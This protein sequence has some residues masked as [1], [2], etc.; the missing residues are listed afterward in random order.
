[1]DGIADLDY[2]YDYT[3]SCLLGPVYLL[4]DYCILGSMG[5]IEHA[6]SL[7]PDSGSF[8]GPSRNLFSGCVLI[9]LT[10]VSPSFRLLLTLLQHSNV[11][12]HQDDHR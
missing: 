9:I 3:G 11:N 2:D 5:L 10:L 6:L 8:C 4:F 12:L 7:F 1:M